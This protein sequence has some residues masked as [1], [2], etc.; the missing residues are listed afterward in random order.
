MNYCYTRKST[1]TFADTE[2]RVREALKERGFGVIT[3]IDAQKTIKEKIG[4]DILPY[5]ILGACDPHSAHEAI[6]LESTIGVFLPCNVVVR[7]EKCH[8]VIS[9]ILPTI[10]IGKT[11]NPALRQIAMHVEQQLKGAVDKAA[12]Q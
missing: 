8:V 10:Q 9:T 11:K 5:K 7:E 2:Q 3:E 6:S 12:E 1:R 4:K